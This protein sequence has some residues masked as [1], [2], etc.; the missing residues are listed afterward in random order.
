MSSPVPIFRFFPFLPF[1]LRREIFILATPPRIVHVQESWGIEDRAH[2]DG[3]CKATGLRDDTAKFSYAVEQ[4]LDKY[5][6]EMLQAKLHPDLAYFACNW[7]HHIPFQG[8]YKQTRLED[9]GFTSRLGLYQPWVP[10]AETPEIPL[11]WL[12]NYPDVAFDLIR[13]SYLYSEAPIPTLLHTCHE[14]RQ[15]LMSYGYRIAFST[16]TRGPRTWFHFG[17]DRLYIKSLVPDIEILSTNEYGGMLTGTFWDILG[18]FSPKDLQQVRNLILCPVPVSFALSTALSSLEIL[19]PLLPNLEELFME[20]W[21]Q[22][23]IKR[24][25]HTTEDDAQILAR[26]ERIQRGEREVKELWRCIPAEETDA[27][28]YLFCYN[29]RHLVP[30]HLKF[31]GPS[32]LFLNKH[33]EGEQKDVSFFE[34]AARLLEEGLQK[35]RRAQGADWNVPAVRVV[36]TCAETI[37]RRLVDGRR[38]FWNYYVEL[39][40]E[41]ATQKPYIPQT[42]DSPT[43]PAPFGMLWQERLSPGFVDVQELSALQLHRFMGFGPDRDDLRNWYL[44]KGSAIEP[45][46]EVII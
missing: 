12:E 9:Y 46:C 25:L 11:S 45:S 26:S 1:E 4:W 15:M 29:D 39:K 32:L 3:F 37:A 18:Q 23:N 28:A 16:R 44:T 2:F 38:T 10:T 6:L 21:N 42:V 30:M 31:P 22:H 14:S 43:P 34:N 5:S 19:L 8:P 40:K 13:G 17:R 24:W 7:R 41:F 27:L 35:M 33:K 20:E 36:H